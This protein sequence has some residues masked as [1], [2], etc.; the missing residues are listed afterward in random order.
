MKRFFLMTIIIV[1]SFLLQS[2]VFQVI[3]LADVV[4]NLLLIITAAIGYMRGRKEGL[5]T[6]LVCGLLID[7]LYG[8]LIG[9]N[10][11]IYMNIGYLNGFCNKIYYRDDFTVP[12]V[13]VG[14][15]DFL[16]NFSIYVLSFL[17]K[18]KLNVFFYIKRIMLP[19]LVYTVLI[20]VVFYKIL[21][22]INQRLEHSEHREV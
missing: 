7:M 2:T 4:P 20:S 13:L 1:V 22:S 8:D 19:E 5:I 11:L 6:G 16:Y 14:I 17:L 15:S 12:I 18:N 21:H 3:A 10:A 9:F